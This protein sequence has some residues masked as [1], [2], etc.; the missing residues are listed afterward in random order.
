MI[1]RGSDKECVNEQDR[2]IRLINSGEKTILE[3]QLVPRLK[4]G[5]LPAGILSVTRASFF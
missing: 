5:V 2:T 1:L 4:A 3:G